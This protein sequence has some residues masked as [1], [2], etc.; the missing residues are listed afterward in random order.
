MKRLPG[1]RRGSHVT[2]RTW[3]DPKTL[4]DFL[5]APRILP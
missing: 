2:K 3:R 5:K 4:R 1:F